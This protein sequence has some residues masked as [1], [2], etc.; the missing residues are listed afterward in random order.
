MKVAFFSMALL[1][2]MLGF[3]LWNAL[4]I[5]EVFD[6]MNRQIGGLPSFS[7]PACL[8]AAESICRYWEQQ[9]DIV[10]LSVGFST[11]DRVSEQA[12]LLQAC[13]ACGD[14]YGF[15]NAKTL[16]L[17]AVGDMHRAERFSIGNLL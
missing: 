10:G 9:A 17:D 12:A 8:E 7:D 15:Q 1:L 3:I 4:Y 11:V 6:E 14:F 13:V 2:L 16:L 5:K